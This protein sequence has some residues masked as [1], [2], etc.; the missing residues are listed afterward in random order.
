MNFLRNLKL[1]TKLVAAIGIIFVIGIVILSAIITDSV[2]DNMQED[3][4]VIIEKQS[5]SDANKIS[6]ILW[7][8][9]TVTQALGS[10]LNGILKTTD[11][12][13]LS[14]NRLHNILEWI[15]DSSSFMDY[16]FLYL[17][18]APAHLKENPL[19][20]TTKGQFMILVQDTD[21]NSAGGILQKKARDS[22]VEG[23]KSIQDAIRLGKPNSDDIFVGKGRKF[24][25]ENETFVG[26]SISVPLFNKN[27]QII[28]VVG[29]VIDLEKNVNGLLK[30]SNF[31]GDNKFLVDGDGLVLGCA[32]N[33]EN[34]LKYIQDINQ[35]KGAQDVINAIKNQKTGIMDYTSANGVKNFAAVDSFAIQNEFGSFAFVSTA[36]KDSVLAPLHR[37]QIIVAVASL[38]FVVAA[39]ILIYFYIQ[40]NLGRRLPILTNSLVSFF[41]FINHESKDIQL[42]KINAN[43]E[44]GFMA[45]LI[46]E[47]IERTK[48]SLKI[49]EEAIT[50]S[51]QTA[52]A[53]ESGDLTA[54][55]VKQP[56]N[57]Q[58]VELKN[59]LNNMLDVLQKEVGSDTNEIKRVFEAY[60]SLDFTTEVANAKGAVETTTNILGEEIRKMLKASASSADDLSKQTHM[61]EESMQKLTEGSQAQAS[62]LQQSAAAVEEI[63]QS[64]QNVSDKTGDATRQAEDIKNI[65]G[66]IKDIADQTNL[67][68]LNAAIEAARA[69]EHG[70]GFA[71]VADEVRKLAERTGKSLGE[72][73]ANVNVLVQ[74]VS[75]M[76]EA[77]KEQTAGV[78]QINEAIAQLETVTNEN[79]NVANNTNDITKNVYN[80]S[81]NILDDVNQKKF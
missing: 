29:S 20:L 64:M 74:S 14:D 38:I 67:L 33:S 23:L 18:D 42:V 31:E 11:L 79:V 71:V 10:T 40:I 19:N 8:V 51:A 56:A 5:S 65:V 69:G 32:N 73:E 24:I 54:R 7:E 57:P 44:L 75:E 1:Q 47:N 3:A 6:G 78:S 25:I 72:I 9:S 55:I 16:G 53:V 52:K 80:I 63:T 4:K 76:S 36:P 34:A 13:N 37:L 58:L 17:I 43:D 28:G 66:V 62:S 50:Q 41:K 22:L 2:S 39:M 68:A 61:L 45:K 77:I 30:E 12:A 70:R 21:V 60:K 49:D 15:M 46:N 26:L 59:V 48:E 81:T 35:H 27:G